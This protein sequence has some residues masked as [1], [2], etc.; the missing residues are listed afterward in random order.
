MMARIVEGELNT[1]IL[2]EG[3]KFR[4]SDN[5]TIKISTAMDARVNEFRGHN[6]VSIQATVNKPGGGTEERLWEVEVKGG[7]KEAFVE[8]VNSH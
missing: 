6:L 4:T 8:M 1:I 5:K 2:E 7:T 3:D